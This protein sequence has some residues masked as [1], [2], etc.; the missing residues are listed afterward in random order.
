MAVCGLIIIGMCVSAC[1]SEIYHDDQV[2]IVEKGG[3]MEKTS[4]VDW[5]DI[6]KKNVFAEENTHQEVFRV[7]QFYLTESRDKSKVFYQQ[8]TLGQDESVLIGPGKTMVNLYV[9]DKKEERKTL[10]AENIPFIVKTEWNKSR[11]MV[12]FCGDGS[13]IVY[14]LDK[15]GIVL[16]DDTIHETVTSFYWSPLESRK[17]YLEQP[18]NAIGLLYYM[19]PQKKAELYETAEQVHYKARLNKEYFYATIWGN[20]P[21]N[22]ET[23]Q[24]VLANADKEAVKVIG[25]G[26]YKDHYFRS[27]LLSQDD[28]FGLTYISNI[29]QVSNKIFVTDEYIYDA[30]FIAEG[31]FI[32]VTG[33]EN[34]LEDEYMLHLVDTKGEE[35]KTWKISGSSVLLSEDGKTGYSSGPKQERIYFENL[36]MDAKGSGFS[37]G[38][39]SRALRGASG[40]YA[41]KFL[42]GQVAD[43]DILQFYLNLDAFKGM[44]AYKNQDN[45]KMLYDADLVETVNT[46]NGKECKVNVLGANSRQKQIDKQITFRMQEINQKWYV[47]DFETEKEEEKD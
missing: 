36:A 2:Y 20:D 3:Q 10:I 38:P 19:K 39:L 31:R 42:G 5:I 12:A 14:D 9:W 26:N 40:I 25:D 45:L 22:Q 16:D 1:G 47:T 8:R 17:L 46:F 18:F 23:V 24:T 11:N 34:R 43:E 44:K 7:N 35:I 30:K 27:V 4:V 15:E 33:I 6:E 29:N 32:Y 37:M 41:E 21:E 28:N 13:L